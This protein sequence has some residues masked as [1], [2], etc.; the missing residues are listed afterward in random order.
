M[1]IA[2]WKYFIWFLLLYL[3][4]IIQVSFLPHLSIKG[5]VPDLLFLVVFFWI[6]LAPEEKKFIYVLSLLTGLLLENYSNLPVF[7]LWVIT[8][9]F[10]V[11]L[12]KKLGSI[13]QG[14]NFVS[15]L[16]VFSAAFLWFKF[17]P[18][19]LTFFFTLCQKKILLSP[20]TFSWQGI[21]LNWSLDLIIV[22]FCFYLY[23]FFHKRKS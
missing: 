20:W 15:L 21:V 23:E 8:L 10:A 9:F 7:G 4:L 2:Y 14:L 17:F 6:F 16:I 13:M 11:L 3:L 18:F 12:V 5:V 19:I 22:I 1:N